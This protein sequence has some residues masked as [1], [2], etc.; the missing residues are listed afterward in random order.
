MNKII[1]FSKKISDVS[2][3]KK[4]FFTENNIYLKKSKREFNIY[5][6]EK[7]RVKCKNCEK[8]LGSTIFISHKIK[9]TICK[10]CFHLNGLYNDTSNFLKK[11][12]LTSEGSNYEY[13]YKKDFNLRVKNIYLPKLN[14][15]KS[16]LKKKF[17]L[18]EIGS[19][20]G[21]FLR[22]CEIKKI[23]AEGYD[24]NNKLVNV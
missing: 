7:K 15:L 14:F 3:L 1:K 24:V 5:K 16:V 4:D 17:S 12:Y 8:K 19:G 18:I 10:K 22:A 2:E 13:A 11:L 6:K 21:H 20:A 9:Y 23:D